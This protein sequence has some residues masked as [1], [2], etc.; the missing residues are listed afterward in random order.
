MTH[1]ERTQVVALNERLDPPYKVEGEI[2]C[3]VCN[4]KDVQ[5]VCGRAYCSNCEHFFDIGDR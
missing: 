2:A 3:E 4:S 1:D 5:I